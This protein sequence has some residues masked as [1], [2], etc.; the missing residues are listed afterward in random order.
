MGRKGRCNWS[1]FSTSKKGQ[2]QKIKR[3]EKENKYLKWM[4]T[5]S[6]NTIMGYTQSIKKYEEFHNMNIVDLIDEA[7]DEQTNSTPSHLL[8]IINRL[9][10]FQEHLIN[11]GLVHG[12]IRLHLG[13]IKS[14][15]KKNRVIIPYLTPLNPKRT[16][17]REYIEYKDVLTKDEI[18]Q[19]L[20]HMRLPAQARV[21]T[22]I[23]GGLSNEECEHLKLSSFIS[24]T[25]KYH[26]EDDMKSALEW[27]SD[28]NHPIIWVTKLVRIKT[29]K[30]YYAVIGAEAVNKIAEAKLY[31]MGLP[32]YNGSDK[33]LNS[34]KKSFMRLCR[35]VNDRLKLGRVA[36]E[37]KLRSHNLRRFHATHISGSALNYEEHSLITNA[38]IDE[39]QGRGKTS[40]QDTYIKTNPIRQKVLYAKV[41][42]NVSLF[43]EY[44][45]RI[46]GDDVQ[47][48]IHDPT[49]ENQKL[50]EEVEKLNSQL[51]EKK[52][53]SEKVKKLREELGE[54][55][56]DEMIGEILNAK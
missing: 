5:L 46:V 44:D 21:M 45:Y 43:H 40:V 10:D 9:E 42:N 47:L 41:M 12:T 14:I 8:R 50:K 3:L 32:S 2:L 52:K 51:Q 19:A 11:Q 26:M 34:N 56:F 37:S 7:I 23:Q 6:K 39:M 17:R 36:E 35:D 48:R 20:N 1:K 4:N 31:E 54:E 24:E 49:S 29:G 33:L 25:R 38:E 13:N 27:L 18:K 28:E 15:Y 22:M 30:P 16:K 53:A 55:T